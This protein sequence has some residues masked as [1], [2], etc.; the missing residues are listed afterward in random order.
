LLKKVAKMC[1]NSGKAVNNLVIL[2]IFIKPSQS[3][4]G[5]PLWKRLPVSDWANP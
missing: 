3:A 1:V 5:Q 2:T 4:L